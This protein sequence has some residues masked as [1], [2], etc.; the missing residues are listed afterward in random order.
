MN[1]SKRRRW[2]LGL[3]LWAS[4]AAPVSAQKFS[5]YLKEMP[6][7]VSY[8]Y[9]NELGKDP[10]AALDLIKATGITNLELS[11]LFGKTAP[12]FRALL[13]ARGMRCTSYGVGYDDLVK[14]LDE[15]MG[16]AKVLGAE[17]V[18]VAWIPHEGKF[19]LA[20]AQEVAAAF[21]QAGQKLR[22]N[23]LLFCYHNHGYEFE[24]H[25]G[26]TLFDYL[27]QHTDPRYVG[28]EM[29]IM[30]TYLPGQDPAA[31]LRKYPKRFLLM[32]V[33]DLKKGV[34]GN[35][36]GQTPQENVV[37]VGTGQLDMKAILKAARKTSIKYFYLEDEHPEAAKQVPLSLDFLRGME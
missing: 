15:V 2:W 6:G 11:S 5:K 26:G 9:R 29:D 34:P 19:T 35:N 21:N 10:A 12:E 22:E 30:W 32:H 17:F 33:K 36:T 18:R 27:V 25:G 13:D 20:K 28:F 3:V 7:V 16:R 31:L 14:K 8:T 23:G 4:L 24:P 1:P 37:V